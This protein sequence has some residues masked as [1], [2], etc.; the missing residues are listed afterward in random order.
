MTVREL[1]EMIV[2]D[3]HTKVIVGNTQFLI[4]EIPAEYMEIIISRFYYS[5]IYSAYILE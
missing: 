3:D 4:F 5:N 1:T 2:A